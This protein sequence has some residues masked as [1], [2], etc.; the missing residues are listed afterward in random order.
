M[1]QRV[2]EADPGEGRRTLEPLEEEA[3]SEWEVEL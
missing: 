3:G 2:G 1:P